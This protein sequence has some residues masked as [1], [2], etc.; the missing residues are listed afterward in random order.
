MKS[1][2]IRKKQPSIIIIIHPATASLGQSGLRHRR[3]PPT[4]RNLRDIETDFPEKTLP[5]CSR[6][7]AALGLSDSR[8]IPE[9]HPPPASFSGLRAS[10]ARMA[11]SARQVSR[12]T[13][14]LA[15]MKDFAFIAPRTPRPAR[16]RIRSPRIS[17]TK[18]AEKRHPFQLDSSDSEKTRKDPSILKTMSY[19]VNVKSWTP[20]KPHTPHMGQA[21]KESTP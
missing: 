11:S 4:G 2:E 20:R 8:L 3:S 12:S 18:E 17:G 21:T 10:Q 6:R 19:P 15:T 13:K 1:I 14:A 16:Q 9:S 5:C 7:K